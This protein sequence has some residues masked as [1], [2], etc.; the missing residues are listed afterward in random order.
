M[1]ASAFWETPCDVLI[2]AALENQ[3][4]EHNASRI[5]AKLIVEAANGPTTTAADDLLAQMGVIVVPDVLA[6]AGGVIVSY[7]EWVQD[8]ASYFWTVEEVNQRLEHIMLGAFDAIWRLAK[9]KGIS[10]RT[11][12]FVIACERILRAR[13]LRGLYP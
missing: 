2:P 1:S 8:F 11:A 13:Q 9:E 5:R 3:I 6:N 4:T 12:T 10:L 7:F